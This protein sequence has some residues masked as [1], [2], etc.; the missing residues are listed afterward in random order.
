VKQA[1]TGV[2][3]IATLFAVGGCS[4][5][6][7]A[8]KDELDEA[9]RR[10]A[11]SQRILEDRMAALE[12]RIASAREALEALDARIAPQIAEMNTEMNRLTQ[13]VNFATEQWE[14]MRL[15]L[16]DDIATLRGEFDLVEAEVLGVREGIDLATSQAQ[17]ANNQSQEALQVHYDNLLAERARLQGRLAEL[18]ERLQAWDEERAAQAAA[19][20]QI[21]LEPAGAAAADPTPVETEEAGKIE[22]RAVTPE[23]PSTSSSEDLD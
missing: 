5:F 18:E 20:D 6:G 3:L 23:Q 17:L 4:V 21:I 1:I 22:I 10:E 9:M 8:T 2:L 7:I 11:A 19:P 15:G 16:V 12:N 14:A 13:D